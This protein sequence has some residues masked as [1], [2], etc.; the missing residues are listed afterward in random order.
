ME[1][2]PLADDF[3]PGAGIFPFVR[4][5]TGKLI[6]GDVANTVAA[7]LNGV[8]LHRRK[9]L[10]NI[11]YQLQS[12]PVVLDVLPG[13]EMCVT[14]VVIT[15]DFRQHPDLGT[16]EHAVWD[17][18]PQDGGM[19]LHIQAVLQTQGQKFFFGQFAFQESRGLIAILGNPFIQQLLIV[20]GI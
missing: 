10:Q 17:G 14:L 1:G 18:N 4:G 13:A 16:I 6:G 5:H 11:R 15:G 8:H 7:G 3:A 19:A 20:F 9:L 12:R 2:T